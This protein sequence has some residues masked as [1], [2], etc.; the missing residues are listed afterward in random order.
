M[1][2]LPLQIPGKNGVLW[3]GG[4]VLGRLASRNALGASAAGVGGMIAASSSDPLVGLEIAVAGLVLDLALALARTER[5]L[6]VVLLGAACN[7]LVLAI[8]LA[9]G[10]VPNAVALRGIGFAILSYLMYGAIGGALASVLHASGARIWHSRKTA[11][12]EER[13][14]HR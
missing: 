3:I 13:V 11:P 14:E 2:K 1:V 8:K 7:G 5:W 4:I 10:S 9:T 12:R 6:A